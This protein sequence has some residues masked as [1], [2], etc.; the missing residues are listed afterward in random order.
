M[1]YV[2]EISSEMR[3]GYLLGFGVGVLFSIIFMFLMRTLRTPESTSQSQTIE[4]GALLG[5]NM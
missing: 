3:S 5:Q 1:L 4:Y 2:F